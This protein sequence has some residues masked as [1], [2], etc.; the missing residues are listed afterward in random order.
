MGRP[1]GS[2][3]IYPFQRLL[4]FVD[5]VAPGASNLSSTLD[6]GAPVDEAAATAAAQHLLARHP[7]LSYGF[8]RRGDDCW[9]RPRPLD[10]S[11]QRLEVRIEPSVSDPPP[12][13]RFSPTRGPFLRVLLP[14]PPGRGVVL[15]TAHI[16]SDRWSHWLLRRD[17]GRAYE[18]IRAGR[19]PDAR[20]AADFGSFV[21]E[22]ERALAAGDFDDDIAHWQARLD[23]AM[24]I[25]A[26]AAPHAQAGGAYAAYDLTLTPA[27][28]TEIAR[29]ARAQRVT[30]FAAS[31][32]TVARAVGDTSERDDVTLLAMTANRPRRSR[33]EVVGCFSNITPLRVDLRRGTDTDRAAA[34]V[35]DL[36]HG[37]PPFD[38]V[39]DRLPD[40]AHEALAP[41][42]PALAIYLRSD[43][44][45][46][47]PPTDRARHRTCEVRTATPARTWGLDIDLMIDL[48]FGISSVIQATFRP[49]RVPAPF[50]RRVLEGIAAELD[51]ASR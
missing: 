35:A 19:A 5:L 11:R 31:S 47:R 40:E 26:T 27:A 7:A 48:N 16:V 30:G 25:P 28:F 41:N 12:V 9:Q 13:A 37:S 38:W 24:T 1:P 44:S 50:V 23:G 4:M 36:G 46:D 8:G 20:P 49:D 45:P 21:A 15:T 2:R 22:D 10:D 3:P 17:L 29:R 43:S 34:V 51:P 39:L 42:G 14:E 32:V 18:A 33:W 6:L